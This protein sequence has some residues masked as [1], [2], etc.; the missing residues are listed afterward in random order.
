MNT[1]R[2]VRDAW[3][4]WLQQYPLTEFVTLTFNNG[5]AK[6]HAVGRPSVVGSL[7][8]GAVNY[9]GYRGQW[10]GGIEG[11]W[12]L[13]SHLLME[14][15]SKISSLVGYW[16]S[17]YGFAQRKPVAGNAFG[18]TLKE[19]YDDD[20]MSERVLLHLRPLGGRERRRRRAH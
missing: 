1:N 13:H 3:T 2:E 7:V 10:V 6:R 20:R 14:D 19:M 15:S 8:E 5:S 17:T 4:E 16:Q 18:Y 9:V 11:D 12:L